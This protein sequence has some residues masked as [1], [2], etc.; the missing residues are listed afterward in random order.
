MSFGLKNGRQTFQRLMDSIY[1][2]IDFVDCYIDE[3]LIIIIVVYNRHASRIQA[4]DI[5]VR[6]GMKQNDKPKIEST[7]QIINAF[8]AC[9]CSVAQAAIMLI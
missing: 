1:R 6:R 5:E 8:R 9:K 4:P 3:I 7:E 2:V